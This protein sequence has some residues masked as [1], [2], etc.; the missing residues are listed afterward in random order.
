MLNNQTIYK[1]IGKIIVFFIVTLLFFNIMFGFVLPKMVLNS[2]DA[3]IEKWNEFYTRTI[4]TDVLIIGSSTAFRGYNPVIISKKMDKKCHNFS[5]VGLPFLNYARLFSDYLLKNRPPEILIVGIDIFG[6]AHDDTFGGIFWLFPSLPEQST[7]LNELTQLEYIKYFKPYGFYQYKNDYFKLLQNPNPRKKE[8]FGFE[9]QD[10]EW[11]D[12]DEFEKKT[13]ILN[14]DTFRLKQSFDAI[15]KN[16]AQTKV[17]I[18]ISPLY[19]NYLESLKNYNETIYFVK[20]LCKKNNFE[21]INLSEHKVCKEKKYFYNYT[22]LNLKGSEIISFYIA[23]NLSI[24]VEK[25][26][27][28]KNDSSQNK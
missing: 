16:S 3:N 7:M 17:V 18:V 14:I 4:N 25:I 27:K 15:K 11:R 20:K 9:P 5:N 28:T 22:H 21:L 24:I 10:L 26:I 12:G 1:F 19:I 23:D 8:Q 2:K 6:L 13:S